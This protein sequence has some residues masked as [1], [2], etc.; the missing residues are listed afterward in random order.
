MCSVNTKPRNIMSMGGVCSLLKVFICLINIYSKFMDNKTTKFSKLTTLAT[1]GLVTAV[2][3]GLAVTA[4]AATLTG[5]MGLGSRGADV[6]SLQQYL[7]ANPSFYPAGLVTGYYGTLTEEAVEKFQT[8]Y[9][10]VSSGTPAS[11]GFGRVGPRTLAKI[12]SLMTGGV[13]SASGPTTAPAI[14]NVAI[15]VGNTSANVSWSTNEN[16]QSKVYYGTSYPQMTET[17][18]DYTAPYISGQTQ[19]DSNPV[20]S[21][22]LSVQGLNPGTTY[23]YVVQSSDPSGNT[24]VTWPAIF[25]TNTY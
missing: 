6:T 7:A 12:N 4:N 10:I 9:G 24:S 11:T 3:F 1:F 23:Y 21:H 16:S 22:S 17:Q 14:S 15:S 5:Q 20:V 2:M 25:V 8:F 13:A 19:S 18:A